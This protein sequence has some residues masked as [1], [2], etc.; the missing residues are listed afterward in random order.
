MNTTTTMGKPPPRLYIGAP[1]FPEAG[2]GYV[3]GAD[4]R[5][6]TGAATDLYVENLGGIMLWDGPSAAANVDQFGGSY[7]EYAKKALQ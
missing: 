7:L 4:L 1:G 3:P 5:I 2:T 6:Y